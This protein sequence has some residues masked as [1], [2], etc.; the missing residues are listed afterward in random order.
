M[1]QCTSKSDNF[2]PQGGR[3]QTHNFV[4]D[5][6]EYVVGP[7][8]SAVTSLVRPFKEQSS[9]SSAESFF[10]EEVLNHFH[11]LGAKI[12]SPSIV[13]EY[14]RNYPEIAELSKKVSDEV[15]RYF[16][17]RAKL[18][19]EVRDH[20]DPDSEYLALYIRVPEYNDSVMERI[21]EIRE[22]YYSSLNDMAGWFLFTTD[23]CHPR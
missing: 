17:F 10:V 16:D 19:L 9:T 2:W 15:Y 5:C 14:L 6:I 11:T 7:I 22:R 4:E 18:Y 21:E 13:G 12:N 8:S 20:D 3:D 1:S 23:F